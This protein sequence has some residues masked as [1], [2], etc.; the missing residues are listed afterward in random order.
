MSFFKDKNFNSENEQDVKFFKTALHVKAQ[1]DVGFTEIETINDLPVFEDKPFIVEKPLTTINGWSLD[2]NKK[3]LDSIYL[4][5]NGEP[6]LKYAH[7]Y[8]RDDI[9]EDLGLNMGNNAGWTIS[10]LSG[11]LKDGCQKITLVGV[12]D[13]RKIKFDNEIQLCKN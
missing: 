3:E 12:Q 1:S 8:P 9:S 2:E 13:D 6:F 5:V 11:Y 4:I 10:F 7:F